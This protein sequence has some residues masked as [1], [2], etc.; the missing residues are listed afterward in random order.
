MADPDACRDWTSVFAEGSYFDGS[1]QHGDRFRF[2]CPS[3][4]GRVSE[5]AQYRPNSFLSI[6]QR[7]FSQQGVEDTESES[8]RASAPAYEDYTCITTPDRTHL[9]VDQDAPGEFMLYLK[10]M[11]PR[12]LEQLKALCE[13][14]ASDGESD[15]SGVPA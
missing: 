1:G 6:H 2:L 13:A 7:G 12:A 15:P 9:V 4:D 5:I 8:V 11:R 10:D 3:G 14:S